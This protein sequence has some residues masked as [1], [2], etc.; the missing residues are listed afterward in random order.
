MSRFPRR[1]FSAL[2]PLAGVL[3]SPHE[4]GFGK[5]T[6]GPSGR[7]RVERFLIGF[8][9]LLRLQSAEGVATRQRGIG[10]VLTLR[11]DAACP[12]SRNCLSSCNDIAPGCVAVT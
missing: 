2:L 12:R 10:W 4:G 5:F 9:G 7:S 11:K 8:D 1:C 6:L 3:Q